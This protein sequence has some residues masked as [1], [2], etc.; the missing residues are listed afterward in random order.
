MIYRSISGTGKAGA[1]TVL[2]AVLLLFVAAPVA[3]GTEGDI[4]RFVD[5][6][7]VSHFTNAPP[8]DRYQIFLRSTAPRSKPAPA[9]NQF[10]PLIEEAAKETGLDFAL[11]K[12]IIKVESDFNIYA[13]SPAGALGLMQIMPANLF[14]LGVLE[15]FDPRQ[16]ILGGSRYL[17]KLLAQYKGNIILA[18]AAYNA[19]PN[20]VNEGGENDIPSITET[21]QYAAKVMNEYYAIRQ[22]MESRGAPVRSAPSQGLRQVAPSPAQVKEGASPPEQPAAQAAPARVPVFVPAP[23]QAA[24]P[25]PAASRQTLSSGQDESLLQQRDTPLRVM[26]SV[27][28]S[29][30]RSISIIFDEQP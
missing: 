5:E 11:I 14:E 6:R 4:Y 10:D 7:G 24:E 20:R 30:R 17:S 27:E 16:N 9:F 15:P 25:E 28:E 18:L 13:V 21:R 3:Q 2:V 29:G 12:A 19:G 1:A 23:A 26:E 8:D 22:S